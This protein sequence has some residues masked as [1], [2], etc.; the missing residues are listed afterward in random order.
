MELATAQR[1]R[2]LEEDNR[3]LNTTLQSFVEEFNHLR[4]SLG[5]SVRRLAYLARPVL[6]Y[7]FLGRFQPAAKTGVIQM[8]ALTSEVTHKT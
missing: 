5:R 2:S 3:N 4:S 8:G 7:Q 1:I 6:I